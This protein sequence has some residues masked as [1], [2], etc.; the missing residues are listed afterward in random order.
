[1]PCGSEFG[2][3]WRRRTR[4]K[5]KKRIE[6]E[7]QWSGGV[8]KCEKGNPKARKQTDKKPKRE[9]ASE[10]RGSRRG[11]SCW[12]GNWRKMKEK[13]PWVGIGRDDGEEPLDWI[14]KDGRRRRAVERSRKGR[15]WSKMNEAVG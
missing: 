5:E 10:V 6:G 7:N 4:E 3:R 1:V 13:E 2:E 8:D 15:N 12:V 9:E 14:E 11:R